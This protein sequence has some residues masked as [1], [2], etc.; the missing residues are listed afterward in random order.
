MYKDLI[1]KEVTLI[2]S[3]RAEIVYEYRGVLVSES[4]EYLKLENV[5]INAVLS[6]MQ[7]NVF[8]SNM[9]SFSEYLSE[10]IIN[11]EYIVSCNKN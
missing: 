6:N 1:G 8:G 4:P 7:R 10:S 9:S 3:S 5:S 11:K 2:V